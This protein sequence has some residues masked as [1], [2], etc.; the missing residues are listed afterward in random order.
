M[1]KPQNRVTLYAFMAFIAIVIVTH[2]WPRLF[3]GVTSGSL[4]LPL[5]PADEGYYLAPI[6]QISLERTNFNHSIYYELRHEADLPAMEANIKLF[7]WLSSLVPLTLTQFTTLMYAICVVVLVLLF[8]WLYYRQTAN[9]VWTLALVAAAIFAHDYLILRAHPQ[10]TFL[11]TFGLFADPFVP[12]AYLPYMRPMNPQASSIIFLMLAGLMAGF[13]PAAPGERPRTA[14]AAFVSVVISLLVAALTALS[15]HTWYF[16]GIY[17]FSVVGVLLA[18]TLF[19]REFRYL[20]PSIGSGLLTGLAFS[21]PFILTLMDQVTGN[22]ALDPAA[23]VNAVPTRMPVIT[24]P[25]FVCL[26]VAGYLWKEIHAGNHRAVLPFVLTAAVPVA[27]NTHVT[28]GLMIEPFQVGWHYAPPAFL[29]AVAWWVGGRASFQEEGFWGIR[30][31]IFILAASLLLGIIHLRYSMQND[32][33]RFGEEAG[34]A[35]VFARTEPLSDGECVVMAGS[36]VSDLVRLYTPCRVYGQPIGVRGIGPSSRNIDRLQ[37]IASV[38]GVTFD[39]A[40]AQRQLASPW[41][42]WGGRDAPFYL[43]GYRARDFLFMGRRM[44]TAEELSGYRRQY[45]D[46]T[47]QCV[48][49][50][51]PFRVDY[52]ITLGDEDAY[53]RPAR[54]CQELEP[55]TR[56]GVARLYRVTDQI[57]H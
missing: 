22:A 19:Q 38:F 39:G 10:E 47:S 14:L 45:A 29:S 41:T 42:G 11:Q 8:S 3:V 1:G 13:L 2:L 49:Y 55:V 17:C 56:S 48:D 4:I 15:I 5:G 21:L 20:A 36:Q 40:D 25:G 23:S 43:F 16:L 27:E 24:G 44:L 33:T 50:R 54:L 46:I 28:T 32:F 35:A 9:S 53:L 7:A 51:D 30:S 26:L 18:L 57:R 34:L 31:S 37:R 12:S 52:I 6:H